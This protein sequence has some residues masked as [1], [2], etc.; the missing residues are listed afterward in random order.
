MFYDLHN[1]NNFPIVAKLRNGSGSHNVKLL[2]SKSE[3]LRY[4]KIMFGSGLSSSPGLYRK[5]SAN[6]RSSKTIKLF[7]NRAKR[8]PEFIRTLKDAKQFPNEKGYVV[9]QEFIPNDGF[10]LK[11]V[12]VGDKLSYLARKV[13]GGDIFYDRSLITKNIIELAF[14]TSDKLGCKCMG[15]DYV[16]DKHTGIGKIVEISYGFSYT[17]QLSAYGYFD[18]S[19]TWHTTPLNAPKVLLNNLLYD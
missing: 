6:L 14:A 18:R 5:T 2:R 8:I 10:D 15:Y 19:G 4:S 1:F 17:A 13:S 7:I 16:V 12:V 3:I 11:I 9:F